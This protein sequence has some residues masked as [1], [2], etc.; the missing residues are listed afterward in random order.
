[1][2]ICLIWAQAANGVIGRDGTLPWH[3]PEDQAHFR[4]VT[5]GATVVMGRRTWDSLP[6]RFRPLPDRR[7]VVL[8]RCP[9]W[10]APGASVAASIL[11]AF[12]SVTSDVWVIGGAQV[13]RAAATIAER[14]VRTELEDPFEGDVYA[15]DL[16]DGWHPVL[17][18]PT[19]GW[20][21]SRTGLRY[22]ISTLERT[23]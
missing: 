9:G 18:D 7:N 6:E 5:R 12:A 4:R 3:L 10:S 8:T 15:P 20:H 11:G 16:G 17:R 23:M 19:T 2:T 14:V 13:Y 22:R 1:V 21:R